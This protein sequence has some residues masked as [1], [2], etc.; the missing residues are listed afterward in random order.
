LFQNIE[1]NE[2]SG[3]IPSEIGKMGELNELILREFD[4]ILSICYI[5]RD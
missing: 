3:S 4:S 5:E 2:L 1:D